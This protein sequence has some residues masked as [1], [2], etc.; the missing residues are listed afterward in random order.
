MEAVLR[1]DR[2]RLRAV[3]ESVMDAVYVC[4]A[5]RDRNG[6]IEDFVF[7]YLN[8]KVEKVVSIPR[9]ILLGGKMCELLPINRELGLFDA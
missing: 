6:E 5:V 7:T 4:E 2:D 9:N 8:D 1:R 3:A